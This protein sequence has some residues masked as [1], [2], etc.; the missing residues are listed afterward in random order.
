M[1]KFKD[2]KVGDTVY[3]PEKVVYGFNKRKSFYLPVKVERVT[4][5]QFAIEGGRMFSKDW[6][7]EIGESLSSVKKLS[8]NYEFGTCKVKDQTEDY[9]K[10]KRKIQLETVIARTMAIFTLKHNSELEITELKELKKA[11][12]KVEKILSKS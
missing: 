9:L 2:V 11:V 12:E 1:E 8:D 10:F 5:T 3:L 6:G 7:S 4:K